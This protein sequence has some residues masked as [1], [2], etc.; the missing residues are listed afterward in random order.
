MTQSVRKFFTS[1]QFNSI[2]FN[3]TKKSFRRLSCEEVAKHQYLLSEVTSTLRNDPAMNSYSSVRQSMN[4]FSSVRQSM[5]SFSLVFTVFKKKFNSF[6]QC[7]QFLKSLTVL[8]QFLQLFYD[9]QFKYFTRFSPHQ[10]SH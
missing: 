7:L 2:Q 10:Q 4:S 6:R 9:H 1:I 5:N 3:R 8:R